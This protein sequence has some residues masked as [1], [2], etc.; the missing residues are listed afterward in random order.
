[1]PEGDRQD[2]KQQGPPPRPSRRDVDRI[3]GEVLP[4]TTGDERD[5]AESGG[6]PDSWYLDNRPPH[7]DR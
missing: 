5:P 4:E 6:N 7:H 3:F 1:M 2:R